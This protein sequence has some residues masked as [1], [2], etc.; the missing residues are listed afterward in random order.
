MNPVP[1][2]NTR[3]RLWDRLVS[4]LAKTAACLARL[5]W[6][7]EPLTAYWPSTCSAQIWWNSSRP[8]WCRQLLH[9]L[10]INYFCILSRI[11]PN[12]DLTN[13]LMGG[14]LV[15]GSLY[16]CS[17]PHLA[18][19]KDVK[20]RAV[21]RYTNSYIC[22]SKLFSSSI[23]LTDS[24]YGSTMVTLGSLLLW[25]MTRVL[26]PDNTP[27]RVVLAAGSSILLLKTGL[28]YLDVVDGDKKSK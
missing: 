22:Q 9:N 7:P 19:I 4:T 23:F 6:P 18:S 28:A 17:R 11:S 26:V 15:G 3:A 13:L 14:S 27:A 16:L 24:L 20:Q 10:K 21:F 25:A 5:L 8:F 12:R 1:I 2:R